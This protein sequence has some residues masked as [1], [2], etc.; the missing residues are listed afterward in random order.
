MNYLNR[1]YHVFL[2]LASIQLLMLLHLEQ[3]QYYCNL[4]ICHFQC[5]PLTDGVI[6]G[7]GYT[8]NIQAY[9]TNELNANAVFSDG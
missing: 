9:C 5:F 2:L 1:L 6:G 4:I 8:V 7:G 3:I